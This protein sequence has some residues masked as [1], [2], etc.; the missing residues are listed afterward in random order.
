MLKC[1]FSGDS[2]GSLRGFLET[3]FRYSQIYFNGGQLGSGGGALGLGCFLQRMFSWLM[4]SFLFSVGE[5]DFLR[6]FTDPFSS[7]V[8]SERVMCLV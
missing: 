1:V 8:T 7:L 4:T 3:S 2:G 6:K 5:V